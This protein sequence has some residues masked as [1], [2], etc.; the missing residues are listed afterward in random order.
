MRKSTNAA[1]HLS[2]LPYLTFPQNLIFLQMREGRA[3]RVAESRFEKS[4]DETAN[5]R[6]R[7]GPIGRRRARKFAPLLIDYLSIIARR[8]WQTRRLT[9]TAAS[10]GMA[11]AAAA[12]AGSEAAAAS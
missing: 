10:A 2:R 11:A 7:T 9:N 3:P 1:K 4:G 8:R 5:K 6:A 12:A